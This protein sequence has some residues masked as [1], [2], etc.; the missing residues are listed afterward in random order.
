M[1]GARDGVSID[2]RKRLFCSTVVRKE[3]DDKAGMLRP[4]RDAAMITFVFKMGT[5]GTSL[6]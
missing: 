4:A 2:A 1:A 6:L 5:G 3:A